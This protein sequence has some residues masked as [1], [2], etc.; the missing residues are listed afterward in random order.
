MNLRVVKIGSLW[1][2]QGFNR[3]NGQWFRISDHNTQSEAEKAGLD[4]QRHAAKP[5]L[6]TKRGNS[7]TLA[8]HDLQSV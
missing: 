3:R 8:I 7:V 5:D 6:W 2:L 4:Y 1:Y